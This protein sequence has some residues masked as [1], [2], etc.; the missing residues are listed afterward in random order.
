MFK[1][2]NV[3]GR[4]QKYRHYGYDKI[5]E[6]LLTFKTAMVTRHVILQKIGN[7]NEIQSSNPYDVNQIQ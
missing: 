1:M 2:K 3:I 7:L 5:E 4:K 6:K